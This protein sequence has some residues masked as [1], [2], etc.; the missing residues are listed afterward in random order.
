MKARVS[1]GQA[2]AAEPQQQTRRLPKTSTA[3]S[4]PGKRRGRYRGR[5]SPPLGS[6]VGVVGSVDGKDEQLHRGRVLGHGYVLSS[7]A[8][9][10]EL[11][12]C[13]LV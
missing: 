4:P 13:D 8:E 1:A 11:L 5:R 12:G 10:V 7:S 6:D 3:T 9:H 2:A